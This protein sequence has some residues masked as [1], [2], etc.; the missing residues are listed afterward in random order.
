MLDI[1][2]V[3]NR[4]VSV[5]AASEMGECWMYEGSCQGSRRTDIVR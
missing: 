2:G 3:S 4:C 5:S 1:T